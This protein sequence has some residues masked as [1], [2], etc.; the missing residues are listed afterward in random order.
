MKSIENAVQCQKC[1]LKPINLKLLTE[2]LFC[3]CIVDRLFHWRSRD[4][5]HFTWIQQQQKFHANII[6]N[7]EFKLL[8]FVLDL[9][10]LFGQLWYAQQTQAQQVEFLSIV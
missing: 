10:E 9:I 6:A 5:V 2:F 7:I 8:Q 1:R 3:G 4:N